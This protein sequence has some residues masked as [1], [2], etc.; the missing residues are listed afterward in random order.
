MRTL[1]FSTLLLLFASCGSIKVN[2]DYDGQTDFTSYSTYNYFGDM[3][4]GLSQ[5]DEKRL[6]DALDATLGEQGYMF[7]EEPDVLINIKSTVFSTQQGN[8]VGVGLG[9]G[10]GRVGGGVSIGIPVGGPKMT[11]ELQIDFV[12]A[13]KDMLIWQAISE[14]PF[15]EGDTPAE[16]S[17]KLQ[18]VVD[19]IFS[20]YPPE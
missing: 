13:N 20:K 14:S 16:K 19:K 12:D 2:Y 18:A 1:L 17:E 11:R 7:A 6:M 5:L 4:T 8:N 3:E 10:G 9:G 15:R